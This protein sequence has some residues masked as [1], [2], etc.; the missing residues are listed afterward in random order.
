MIVF[1]FTMASAR[2]AGIKSFLSK[3]PNSAERSGGGGITPPIVSCK[4]ESHLP[5]INRPDPLPGGSHLATSDVPTRAQLEHPQWAL[6][7]PCGP[8]LSSALAVLT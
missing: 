1:Q 2:Q 8:I 3:L 5:R 6:G 4:R 7:F